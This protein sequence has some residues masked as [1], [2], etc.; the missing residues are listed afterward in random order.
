MG[1]QAG[2]LRAAV[3]AAAFGMMTV[4]AQATTAV[5]C[6]GTPAPPTA[7]LD[8]EFTLTTNP[9]ATCFAF[10]T[11]NI[12]GNTS[13]S[14][15]P[16]FGLLAT[17]FGAGHM[18]ID[19]SDDGTSGLA[20][21]ALTAVTGSLVGGLSGQFSFLLPTLPVGQVWQNVIIA[22]KSGQGQ[23]DP[24]WAAF[25]LPVGVTSGR[26]AISGDQALSHVNIYAQVG[27]VPPPPPPVPLPAA[28]WLMIAG[29]GGLAALRRRRKAA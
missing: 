2:F 23:L 7:P 8:R 15:D 21:T 14:P 11:G 17:A 22:F 20:P 3:V 10:G 27:R 28:G 4:A 6:P 9:G 26:W 5:N 19:K 1:F 16:L 13:G 12:N 29:L 24:D 18:L 25:R